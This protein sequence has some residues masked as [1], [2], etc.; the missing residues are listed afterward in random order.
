[1]GA[2]K[3]TVGRRVAEALGVPWYDTDAL[4]G[5]PT[6]PPPELAR[7]WAAAPVAAQVAT[8]EAGFRARERGLIEALCAVGG[9]CVVSTGGGAWADAVA[10]RALRRAFVTV[11]LAAPLDVLAG[12]VGGAAGRP[13][14][15]DR[16]AERFAARASAYADA[17]FVVDTEG[18][19]VGAVVDEVLRVYAEATNGSGGSACA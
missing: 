1:M 13:L 10:R 7:Y 11:T 19:G 5:G 9:P 18:R 16:V 4:L 8:D 12:R 17:D 3:S 14:W 2:G 15:D 6:P